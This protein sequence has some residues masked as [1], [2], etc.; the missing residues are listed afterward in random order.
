M[1]K[2]TSRG[3]WLA[4]SLLLLFLAA[5]PSPAQ[6]LG[7][8]H[9]AVTVILEKTQVGPGEP[10]RGVF[11][12]EMQDGWH[13]YWKNAGDVGL[14]TEVAWTLPEGWKA[15]PLMFP[16]PH[17]LDTSG[18]ISYAYEDSVDLPF[19]LQPEP[20]ASPQ[21][22][23]EVVAKLSWLECQDSCVPGDADLMFGFSAGATSIEGP[24]ADRVK[25]AFEALPKP[26]NDI[27][28]HRE[29]KAL[30]LHLPA[31]LGSPGDNFR[32][33]PDSAGQVTPGAPQELEKDADD[34]TLVLKLQ[35]DASAEKPA[36]ELSG[37]LVVQKTAGAAQAYEFKTSVLDH[38]PIPLVPETAGFAKIGLTL[39]LAFL[40][41][42]VLNLMPCVFPVLSLKVLGIVEQ[43]RHEGSKPWHHGLVFTLGVLVSFWVMSGLLL[44]V[45]AAGQQVGWGYHLQ[46]PVMIAFLATLFLLI[47]LNLFGVFEVGENLTQLSNVAGSKHGFAH[48]FWSGVLTTLAATPCTAPFMGSAVGFALSQ[49]AW[50]ALLVFSALA[51]GVAA[52]YMT[53]TLFPR[54]LARLPRPGAWMITFKQILAFPMLVAVVWLVWVFGSQL[55]SDRM[56]MLL[57]GLVVVSFACWIYG[58][59]G[60]SYVDKTRRL[61]SLAA[62]LVM[63]AACSVGYQASRQDPSA[64]QWQTFSPELVETLVSQGKPVFV[65]FTA[66]WCTSCKANELLT[67]SR[68]EINERFESLGVALV[69]GDWTKKDPVITAAL[70]K[71]GRAGVPLYVLYPGQGKEP[72]V[73]PEVLFPGTV[74][75]ALAAVKKPT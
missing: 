57:L 65:D 30:L 34:G 44:V 54:L 72:V 14:P 49:P 64:E 10:L 24:E 45:R 52:P 40:G 75:D 16:A 60:N 8:P 1:I 50:V 20:E 71:Y 4:I 73:L 70:A 7:N 2:R 46:N 35:P 59:W 39:L 47:G 48:S 68:P 61:G 17:Y 55:G 29:G 37:V 6:S 63:L 41:G 9:T 27:G 56:A 32:F 42:V 22:A 12:M 43:S 31:S 67:L 15:A 28:A 21:G 33:F 23:Q 13:T 25:T 53:L 36:Q 74:L 5:A 69:K 58:K 51:L 18:L 11:H 26:R 38:K 19:E 62:A 3:V 66:D